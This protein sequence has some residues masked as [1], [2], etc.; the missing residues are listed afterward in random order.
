MIKLNFKTYK[1]LKY[2]IINY[3]LNKTINGTT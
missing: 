2:L 1:I 3:A